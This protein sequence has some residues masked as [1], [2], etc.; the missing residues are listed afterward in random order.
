MTWDVIAPG[1][2]LIFGIIG[3]PVYAVLL[4]WFLG[5]PGDPK[6]AL[7]GVAYL[8]GLT[9]ALWAGMFVKTVVIDLVFF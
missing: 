9:T 1:T 2:W 5:K 6:R 7:M 4:G 3:L 8:V